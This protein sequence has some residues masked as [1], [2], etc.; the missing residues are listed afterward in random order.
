MGSFAFDHMKRHAHMDEK[1]SL[2]KVENDRIRVI[3]ILAVI[4]IFFWAGFQ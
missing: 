3:F 1:K 4:S 2:T